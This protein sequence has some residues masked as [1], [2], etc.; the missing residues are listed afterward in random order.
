MTA[1]ALELLILTQLRKKTAPATAADLRNEMISKNMPGNVI[2]YCTVGRI[3][4]KLDVLE[5]K[6]LVRCTLVGEGRLA[7][8][9][10]TIS[11]LG[12]NH[13]ISADHSI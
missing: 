1:K 4:A 3:F 10:F 5:T 13:L 11:A 9:R 8:A 7:Q 6:R 12:L 2:A